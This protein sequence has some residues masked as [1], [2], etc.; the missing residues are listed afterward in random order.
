MKIRNVK[1]VEGFMAA[2]DKC[3]GPV[4]L[5]SADGCRFN[6][7]SKLSQYVALGAL[8]GEK[9]DELDLFCSFAEDRAHFYQF[10][11]ENPGVN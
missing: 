1:Q 4:W 7:Q 2:V 3:V 10:F 5:E 11:R 6:L 8:L 9:G